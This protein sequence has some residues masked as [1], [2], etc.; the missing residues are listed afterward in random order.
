MVPG[1]GR[2]QED[3]GHAGLNGSTTTVQPG[4]PG[5]TGTIGTMMVV[6]IPWKLQRGEHVGQSYSGKA[7]AYHECDRYTNGAT[8]DACSDFTGSPEGSGSC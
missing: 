3:G 4:G 8:N 2:E 5:Q 6:S 1:R 7:R